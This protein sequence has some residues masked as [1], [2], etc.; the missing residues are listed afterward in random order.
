[1][2]DATALPIERVLPSPGSAPVFGSVFGSF[3]VPELS[4]TFARAREHAAHLQE[5]RSVYGEIYMRRVERMYHESPW[6][7]DKSEWM[8]QRLAVFEWMTAA[9][10]GGSSDV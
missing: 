7:L 8:A 10:S 3:A 5:L 9:L 1:M 6:G 2:G 4:N